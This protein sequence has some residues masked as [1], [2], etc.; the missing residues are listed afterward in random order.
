MNQ[1]A[2]KRTKRDK[3]NAK[4]SEPNR[5]KA[6]PCKTKQQS[7]SA[8]ANGAAALFYYYIS[9][10]IFFVSVYFCG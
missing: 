9:P 6:N 7:Q 8:K 1:T 5:N 4:Q 3:A 2:I 10:S